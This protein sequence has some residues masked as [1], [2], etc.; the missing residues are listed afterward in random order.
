MGEPASSSPMADADLAEAGLSLVLPNSL[1][2][3]EEG[4]LPL[5]AFASRHGLGMRDI[6]R[7]E[8]IFEEVV[9]NCVRHGFSPGSDQSV[10]VRGWAT[11][12]AVTLVFDDDGRP[13]NPL[14]AAAPPKFTTLDSAVVG[15]RGI[16]LVK[17]LAAE[18]LYEAGTG[19]PAPH[20]F[21]RQNRLTVTLARSG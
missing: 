17:R 2:A 8:V 11:E 15:G 16:D 7:I 21:R 3:V 20:G 1:D 6:N 12:A 14:T 13:F 18:V 19:G 10:R 5:D 9:S 4:R